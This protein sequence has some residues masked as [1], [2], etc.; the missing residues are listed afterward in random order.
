MQESGKHDIAA[1]LDAL[2]K[3][4]ARLE[5]R[6]SRPAGS[7]QLLA[8]S[9]TMPVEAVQD[10]IR[11]GQ[12]AF[13]ENHLQDARGKIDALNHARSRAKSHA[14]SAGNDPL[15]WHFIGDIQSNKTREIASSFD[16]V[17]SIG[18]EK[19][20]RRL[21]EQRPPDLPPLRVCLEVNIG[22]EATKAGVA[23]EEVEALATIVRRLPNLHLR[24]LMAI[25]PPVENM[26]AARLP[27]RRLRTLQE[28]LNAKGFE[29]DTLSMGMSGDLEAAIAEGATIVRIGTAIFGP[30]R[31]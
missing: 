12:R 2:R 3:K 26:E 17:H 11:Q 28:D 13:G 30:R 16:W 25:P 8:V 21:S 9:K 19:I 22:G 5:D 23:P 6:H 4:I 1:A 29:L 27:F 31:R 20:A 10:A 15:S 14:K 18:R 7:V 24:G